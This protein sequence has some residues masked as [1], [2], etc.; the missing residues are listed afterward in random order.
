MPRQC[1]Y[2]LGF[3]LLAHPAVAQETRIVMVGDS[4]MASYAKPP[5]DR[6]DLTGWGQVF[7]EWFT[8]KATVINH[9]R[10]GA[11]SKSFIRE[12]L[13]KKALDAK[14]TYVFIQFGHNDSPG[15]GERSTE[16]TGDYQD[17]LK[18]Y[19]AD[20]RAINAKPIL[21]TPVGRRTFSGDKA[22]TSLQPYAD[23]MKRVGKEKDV[24][25]IDLHAASMALYDKLGD[26]GSAD[27]SP[28]ASDRSHFSRKGARAIAFLVADA[29]GANVPGLDKLLKF[30][31]ELVHFSSYKN[32]PV[33]TPVKGEWDAKIR[34]RGWI[35]REGGDWKLW[36]TGY[37]GTKEGQRMLGY[38]TSKDGVAWTRHP[39]NPLL[40]NEWLEDMMIVKHD[41]KYHM[42]A[43]GRN[44][45]AHLLVSIDGVDWT[46]Q[47]KLD[48]RL[49]NG[50]PI[51]DGPFGTPTAWREKE[52]WYLFYERNDLGVWLAT[53]T[54]MKVWTNV[55]D[56]PVMKPGPGEYEKDLIA[57]N[58]IIQHNGRYYAYYHGSAREGKLKGLWSTC[59]ATSTDLVNWEKYPG[60][61]LV[62]SAEN[63]SSGIL[64]HD[65]ERYRLYTMH[66]EVHLFMPRVK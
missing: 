31:A 48:I 38:A 1:L 52:R 56:E 28:A 39:K 23:A 44:D 21:V 64:V 6:P 46:Q 58:Q 34:E 42:F 8:D 26:Q 32:N 63:K 24:P 4:T 25:V 53:S 3:L 14:P 36:Y 17:Y 40:K 37:D 30:P 5:A 61:P 65:G 16:A 19:I 60:N 7:G 54:D 66:P 9:A 33:F 13:W 47:R 45:V 57:L 10:S 29:L 12:G 55:Q 51:A 59:V 49:K 11:S 35:R 62:P 41:G 15:R 18:Q 2:A 20:A 22:V 27:F 43:E 50:K